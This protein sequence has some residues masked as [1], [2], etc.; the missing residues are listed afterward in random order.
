M[1][2]PPRSKH[3]AR[4]VLGA[5]SAA[6]LLLAMGCPALATRVMVVSDLHY[7][8]RELYDGSE[9]FIRALKAGDGKLTQYSDALMSALAK[10]ALRESADALVVTGD[11]SFNGEKQ[12]HLALAKWFADIEKQGVPV[13]VLPGNHDINVPTARG[14]RG[15]EWYYTA[16]V[17][18]E[19]FSEIYADFME[20]AS[21]GANLSYVAPIDDRMKIAMTDVAY[22][23]G[24]AQVFGVFMAGHADW[25]EAASRGAGEAELLTATHHSL[26]THTEF[27]KDS[28]V[29]L[30]SETMSA[31]VRRCG[32]RL[33][34]S[35]HLHVQHIAQEGGLTDA[36][37]GAFCAWP[38]RYALV[39]LRDDGALE[40]EAKSLPGDDLPEGFLDMSRAWY[41][42]IARE[43]TRAMLSDLE[44]AEAEQMAD[45]AARFNLAYFSGTYRSD[46]AAWQADPGYVLWREH[47]DNPFWQYMDMVMNEQSG[48]NL[49]WISQ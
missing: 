26:L 10:Q 4:V 1:R 6:L 15:D 13:W 37:L 12:S 45:F 35:G 8:A 5:F 38:H 9:L 7:M 2:N 23:D 3:P 14:F 28:Y 30:G 48:D 32:V 34:L 46:D 24:A 25:L 43:K 11:L 44:P 49:H 40:Y 39:T 18:P 42:D 47:S 20:P 36:A 31:L 29:M 17:T 16:S 33:N 41:L 22:Y 21:G 19:E 27:M